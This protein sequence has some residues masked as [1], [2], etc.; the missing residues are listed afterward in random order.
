M[1]EQRPNPTRGFHPMMLPGVMALVLLAAMGYYLILNQQSRT[2]L[3]E[4]KA[5]EV[6]V[7]EAR[8]RLR[9]LEEWESIRGPSF[10]WTLA[11]WVPL[12]QNPLEA[13]LK[14]EGRILELMREVRAMEPSVDWKT[15]AGQQGIAQARLMARGLFPSYEALL[16]WLGELEEG[17]PP[18]IPTSI[19]IRKEGARLRVSTGLILYFRV[20]HGTL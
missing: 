1:K 9:A 13:R 17:T 20:E 16:K 3:K 6:R 7:E 4:I 2:L 8:G 12:F 19:E 11:R 18:M 14:L 10:T 5:V 15:P